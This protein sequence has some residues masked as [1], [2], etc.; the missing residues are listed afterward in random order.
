MQMVIE[1]E[2][3]TCQQQKQTSTKNY[4]P[5]LAIFLGTLLKQP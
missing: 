2:A 5:T 4:L 3:Q 1:C